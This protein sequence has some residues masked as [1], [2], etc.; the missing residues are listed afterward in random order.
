MRKYT[1]TTGKVGIPLSEEE[2]TNLIAFMK[3]LSDTKFTLRE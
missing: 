1:T 3:T 2:K